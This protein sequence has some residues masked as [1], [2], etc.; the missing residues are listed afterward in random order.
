LDEKERSDVAS[1]PCNENATPKP[2]SQLKAEFV[3]LVD[4]DLVTTREQIRSELYEIVV[5]KDASMKPLD[6]E[7]QL[8]NARL[9]NFGDRYEAEFLALL[10]TCEFEYGFDSLADAFVETRLKESTFVTMH[11]IGQLFF[12]HL[13][14]PPVAIG[15]LRVLAHLKYAQAYPMGISIAIAATRHKNHEVQECGIRAF[16]NWGTPDSLKV[17][18]GLTFSEPWIQE[19]VDQVVEDLRSQI[20]TNYA[21]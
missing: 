10:R 17:L 1:Q 6:V 18:E 15:I 2:T 21:S 14:D 16:E 20:V 4:D 13:D 7:N 3:G 12:E 5:S 11:W 8:N 19:Y 9:R